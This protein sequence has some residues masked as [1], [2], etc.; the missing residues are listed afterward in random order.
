ML[1][2]GGALSAL[3]AG[4]AWIDMTSNSPIAVRPIREL[5]IKRGVEVLDAPAGGGVQAARERRLQLYV[6]GDADV[7]SKHRPLLETITG[8]G[9]I[10]HVGGHGAGYTV[11][12]LVNLLWFG[13]AVATAEAL[14]L[15]KRTGID[16]RVLQ[17]TLSNS[18]AFS[19]F[20]GC[21]L[22]AL[23]QG[24]YLTSFGLDG[25]CQELA[26][27]TELARDQHVPFELSSLVRR[28]YQRALARYGPVDGE[29]LAVALLEEQTGLDLRPE[30]S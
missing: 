6:G 26:A 1:G 18:A 29:L 28:T 16:L 15:G 3:A 22:E 20:I 30:A 9:R 24:D 13:Q 23:F 27:V 2:A 21:D 25:I 11:K 17:E 7:L 8:P 4:A 5:A 10:A 12:L 14:L 19:N